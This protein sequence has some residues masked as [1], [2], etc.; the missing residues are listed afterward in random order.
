M[1]WSRN[2]GETVRTLATL[3]KPSASSSW[4][5]KA[6][7]SMRRASS[8]SMAA[9]YSARLSRWSATRPGLGFAAAAS[10]SERSSQDTNPSAAAWSGRGTPGGGIIPPRTLRT[11]FSHTSA[12]PARCARSMVSNVRLAVFAR[13]LWHVTQYWSRSARSGDLGAAAGAAAC[14]E[15][16]ANRFPPRSTQSTQRPQRKA[17]DKICEFRGFGA[18]RRGFIRCHRARARAATGCDRPWTRTGPDFPT[19]RRTLWSGR[20]R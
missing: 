15:R 17:N 8:S 6:L 2:D 3:S 7:A 20:R 13:W 10:S 12:S 5:R 11:T 4:G 19:S 9:A 16:A 18:D 14:C 1:Y